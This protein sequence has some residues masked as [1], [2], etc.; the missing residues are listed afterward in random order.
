MP[1]R[2]KKDE[3]LEG[4]RRRTVLKLLPIAAGMPDARTFAAKILELKPPAW[5]N[6]VGGAGFPD[7][8][9]KMLETDFGSRFQTFTFNRQQLERPGLD[10]AQFVE[11]FKGEFVYSALRDA[12][13]LPLEF[14]PVPRPEPPDS[15]LRDAIE[16]LPLESRPVRRPEPPH[17]LERFFGHFLGLYLCRDPADTSK[18]AVATDSYKISALDGDLTAARIEQLTNV[19]T[20]QA[21]I[22]R[23]R[24]LWDT[25]E[26]EIG[27]GNA[28]D[29]DAVYMACAPR[30]D[31]INGMLAIGTDIK[32]GTRL[33][34][35]RPTLFVRVS[36]AEVPNISETYPAGSSLHAAVK[37]IFG[38][39]IAFDT[40]K[41][42]LAPKAQLEEVDEDTVTRELAVIRREAEATEPDD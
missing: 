42:E 8:R 15:A 38:K 26:I 18:Q 1:P 4:K 35:A 20:T 33:V 13:E 10:P 24:V 5:G 36:E 14:R 37:F 6:I 40:E 41:F 7:R 3:T 12:I 39:Y 19:F 22:G 21:S 23:L 11:L 9:L 27:Q 32:F 25:V 30:G 31:K 2:A 16:M 34:V 28:K 29:P 17:L